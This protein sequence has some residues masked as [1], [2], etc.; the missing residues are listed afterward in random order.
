MSSLVPQVRAF[1]A[2]CAAGRL[3]NAMFG[4]ARVDM[5]GIPSTPEGCVRHASDNGLRHN[6]HRV[7]DGAA[8][9]RYYRRP[10]DWAT[11]V[12]AA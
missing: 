12:I 5:R 10:T 1:A 6:A 4:R 8:R 7:I 9:R 3:A 11:I 2:L